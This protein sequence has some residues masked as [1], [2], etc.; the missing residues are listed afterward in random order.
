[1]TQSREG[2]KE[3]ILDYQK[4]LQEAKEKME[5]R[6]ADLV[7]ASQSQKKKKAKNTKSEKSVRMLEFYRKSLEN[8]EKIDESLVRNIYLFRECVV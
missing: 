7:A 4:W 6:V 1:M 2:L 8:L 5:E 3:N